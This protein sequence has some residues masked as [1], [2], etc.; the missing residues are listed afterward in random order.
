MLSTRQSFTIYW[1]WN[2]E[3]ANEVPRCLGV[4]SR[5]RAILFS[6][7]RTDPQADQPRV[8]FESE[9]QSESLHEPGADNA[10]PPAKRIAANTFPSVNS[11]DGSFTSHKKGRSARGVEAAAA[12]PEALLR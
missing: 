8:L 2:Q 10:I 11:P 12:A 7:E 5:S 4:R 1:P 6:S 9:S 3:Q